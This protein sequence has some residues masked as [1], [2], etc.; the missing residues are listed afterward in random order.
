MDGI[1]SELESAPHPLT[2]WRQK[3]IWR[4]NM[5]GVKATLVENGE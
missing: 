2:A 4:Q 5:G 1:A 3:A